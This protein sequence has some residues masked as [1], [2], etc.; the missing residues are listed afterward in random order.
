MKI[1]LRRK[2]EKIDV[3]ADGGQSAVYTLRE[4]TGPDRVRY[5]NFINSK[6]KFDKQG[7][8]LGLRDQGDIVEMLISL[9]LLDSTGAPVPAAVIRVWPSSAQLALFD[10]VREMSGLT[11]VDTSE[12]DLK[13]EST[14]SA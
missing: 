3:T 12:A 1:D 10:R 11:D 4:L 7:N 9:A 13:N 14:A 6:M 2:E 5:Q 8:A